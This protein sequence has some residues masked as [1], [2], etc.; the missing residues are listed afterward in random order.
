MVIAPFIGCAGDY[1]HSKY[2]N[3]GRQCLAQVCIFLRCVLMT[4]MLTCVPRQP[5]SLWTF[6]ILA[7]LVGLLAGWPGVGVNRPI[8]TEIVK[9][10][11]RATTFALVSCLEGVG[12]AT[13]GAPIVGYMC[14]NV[15]G[16]VKPAHGQH[17]SNPPEAIRLGNAQAIAFAM[18]FMTVGPWLL[19]VLAYGILH[20]TYK[21]DSHYGSASTVHSTSPANTGASATAGLP[22]VSK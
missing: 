20:L 9:P 13:L 21:F 14:E 17:F 8:L 1:V 12:A 2:P 3:H 6:F 10:E 7:I 22:L 11:H 15:F 16:Y 18:L 19:N 4:V 5:E